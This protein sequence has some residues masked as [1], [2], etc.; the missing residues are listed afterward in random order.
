MLCAQ[1]VVEAAASSGRSGLRC[2][3]VAP[4][5]SGGTD[6]ASCEHLEV[7]LSTLA[8]ALPS[9]RH[10]ASLTL[11]WKPRPGFFALL[12]AHTVPHLEKLRV[13]LYFLQCVHAW[14]HS[15]GVFALLEELPALRVI[16]GQAGWCEQAEPW[17]PFNTQEG[18]PEVPCAACQKRCHLPIPSHSNQHCRVSHQR[19]PGSFNHTIPELGRA[20]W[21]GKDE[22]IKRVELPAVMSGII[23]KEYGEGAKY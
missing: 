22:W 4:I 10:L 19:L 23:V 14:L 21:F 2:I 13:E 20:Y 16:A 11:G 3:Q 8:L 1:G 5:Q 6:R 15:E 7:N 18:K 17:N 9:L 12:N